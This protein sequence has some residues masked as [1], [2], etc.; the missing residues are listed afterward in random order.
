MNAKTRSPLPSNQQTGLE[1]LYQDLDLFL[2]QSMLQLDGEEPV[3]V[4]EIRKELGR[5]RSQISR[6]EK[7]L[8]GLPSSASLEKVIEALAQHGIVHAGRMSETD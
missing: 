2:T 8:E 4:G 6:V 3:V 5:L 1:D 7:A